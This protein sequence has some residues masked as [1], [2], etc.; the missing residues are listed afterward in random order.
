MIRHSLLGSEEPREQFLL[1]WD[2]GVGFRDTQEAGRTLLITWLF[3]V[4]T[5]VGTETP[6]CC[7]REARWSAL[8]TVDCERVPGRALW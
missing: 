8:Y 6:F 2:G 5:V 4:S 7:W 3:T 1:F